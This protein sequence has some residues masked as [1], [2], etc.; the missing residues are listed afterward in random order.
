MS[1]RLVALALGL[2][3]LRE[4][5][6]DARDLDRLGRVDVATDVQ[7]VVVGRDLLQVGDVGEALD[8]GVGAKGLG[9]A[10]PV[11]LVEVVLGLARAEVV[12]PGRRR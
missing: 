5:F 4:G 8:L 2:A 9:D 12:R 6:L 10:R 3:E 1:G 7:V 11:L